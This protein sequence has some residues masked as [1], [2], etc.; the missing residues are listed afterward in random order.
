MRAALYARFSTENQS[1][2]SIDDQIRACERTAV[3]QGLDVVRR[4]SDR[5]I[6]AGT[7]DRP[8]YQSLLTAA[9]AGEFEVIVTEDLSRLWRNRA[10]FGARSAELEDLNVQL[11]TCTGDDTRRDGY[12][13]VLGIKSAM[14]EAYRKEVS[15]RTRRGMEGLAA[16][17]KS[18]GGKCY[19]YAPGEADVV[20]RIFDMATHGAR[21]A[22]IARTLNREGVPGPRGPRWSLNAAKRILA[23]PRYR[24]VL[25]WGRTQN[26]TRAQDGRRGRPIERPEGP[27]TVRAIEPIVT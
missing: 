19:G 3:S 13:L 1:E 12:G 14:A 26:R 9:R 10:E 25:A 8:G 18:T 16:A 20:R 17:G 24:G 5:S 21:C 6:S 4:F 27:L 22:E 23:N 15:Y 7:A 11:I 2:A